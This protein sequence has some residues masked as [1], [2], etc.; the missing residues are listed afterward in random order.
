MV[1]IVLGYSLESKKWG[2]RY[3]DDCVN[4]C[5][6]VVLYRAGLEGIIKDLAQLLSGFHRRRNEP[7]F[8]GLLV[9]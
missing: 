2:G 5:G 1:I 6:G 8:I 3:F 9:K 4:S 7:D